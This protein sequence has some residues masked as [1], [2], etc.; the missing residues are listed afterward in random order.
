MRGSADIAQIVRDAE[1]EWD[2][3][4]AIRAE[5]MSKESYMAWRKADARGAARIVGRNAV[6]YP[7]N[8]SATE[9]T[10]PDSLATRQAQVRQQNVGRRFAGLPLLDLPQS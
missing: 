6:A 2:K 9:A 3:D 5:F 7:D 4:A 10:A 8:A 1:V